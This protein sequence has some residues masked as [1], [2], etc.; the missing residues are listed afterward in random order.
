LKL[1]ADMVGCR[2]V[3]YKTSYVRSVD[4][5]LAAVSRAGKREEKNR[6]KV[7]DIEQSSI[8][9]QYDAVLAFSVLKH[10]K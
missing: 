4:N 5:S 1:V 8:D 6:L 9:G 10:P 7:M 2:G 3:I